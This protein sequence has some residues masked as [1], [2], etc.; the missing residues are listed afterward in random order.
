M[1]ADPRLLVAATA[2]QR[3]TYGNLTADA[4]IPGFTSTATAA[5]TTTLT[6]TATEIQIFTG[7]TTQTVLLPTTDVVEGQR[8]TVINLSTDSVTVNASGGGFVLSVGTYMAATFVA[9]ID[10]PTSASNWAAINTGLVNAAPSQSATASTIA[11]RDGN[12][13]LTADAFIPGF[14]TTPTAAGTTALTDNS[15]EIQEFTGSTTQTITLPSSFIRAGQR[16]TIINSST[17]TLTVNSSGG[18][19]V[20]SVPAGH[21]AMMAP[22]IA[23]PTTAANWSAILMTT[24][25]FL[26][27]ATASS[28]ALRDAQANLVADAFIPGATTASASTVLTVDSPQVVFFTGSSGQTITLPTTSI[29]RGQSYTIINAGSATVTVAASDAASITSIPT[30][31]V[32]TVTATQSTPTTNTHWTPVITANYSY[33]T[34][35]T[36][37][38]VAVRDGNGNLLSDSFIATST[39]TTTSAGTLTMTIDSSQT[40]EFTGSTTHTV[41]L[42]T[43]S[44]VA[45]QTYS[46]VNNSSGTVTVQSSGANTIT[47]VAGGAA[48]TF[49]AQVAT[50]TTAANWRY[51]AWT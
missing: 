20:V 34:T 49:M 7:T 13:N 6:V 19:L 48:A 26:A 16:Y 1:S 27:T 18:N 44:V 39:A 25:A 10:E 47:T 46:I 40:Q 15:T 31:Q 21:T 43:T 11:R 14:T 24:S 33:R 17:G 4:V 38:S 22:V 3:D 29:A 41:K 28:V 37:A 51:L 2:A 9:L 23:T 8:Y 45:G 50:P 32:A 12:A 30:S 35:A 36:I 42:P 5:G